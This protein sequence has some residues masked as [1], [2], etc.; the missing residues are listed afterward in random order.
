MK[1][2]VF[3]L[4]QAGKGRRSNEDSFLIAP[5]TGLFA[6]AD[7]VG[8]NYSGEVASKMAVDAM[9][10]Y[11]AGKF[12]T[13][14]LALQAKGGGLL[15]EAIKD[16]NLRVYLKGR[17]EEKYREMACT[18]VAGL[19]NRDEL[20]IGHMGDSR[21]YLVRNGITEQLTEDHTW[22]N[23]QIESG[24]LTPEEAKTH[25][26]RGAVTKAIGAE[27]GAEPG[28]SSIR[29]KPGDYFLFCSDGLAD[30]V[31]RAEI[32]DTIARLGPK[33][34]KI[35][36]TLVDLAVGQGSADDITVILLHALK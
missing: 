35:S 31:Q 2:R 12:E 5:K 32:G 10:N 6:V 21:L 33:I 14:P 29:I 30:V 11:I 19:L 1:I 24:N 15:A 20:L 27:A 3:G 25:K 34:R 26:M 23:A 17:S 4:S 28:L 9:N 16:A 8:G 13:D 7:G 22:V 36:E 18:V